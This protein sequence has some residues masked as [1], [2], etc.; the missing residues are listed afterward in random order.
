[1]FGKIQKNGL[2]LYYEKKAPYPFQNGLPNP[3]NFH[4]FF[5]RS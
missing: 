2:H 4:D 5:F 3:Q 1:M